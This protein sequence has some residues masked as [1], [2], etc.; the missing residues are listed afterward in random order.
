MLN[1]VVIV[2]L[3]VSYEIS[4]WSPARFMVVYLLLDE[5]IAVFEVSLFIML[6]TTVTNRFRQQNHTLRVSKDL[7]M[8]CN[9][10]YLGIFQ[11][12][13]PHDIH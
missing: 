13:D 9:V 6:A 11:S 2:S 7:Q 4:L 10:E 12:Y 1:S 5:M 8:Q 3:W